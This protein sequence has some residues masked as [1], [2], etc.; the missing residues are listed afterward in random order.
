MHTEWKIKRNAS[1]YKDRDAFII[2]FLVLYMSAELTHA[3]T[4]LGGILKLK[5]NGI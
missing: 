4:G 5:L 3:F 1:V 2:F